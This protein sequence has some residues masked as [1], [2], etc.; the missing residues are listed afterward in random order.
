MRKTATAIL[1]TALVFGIAACEDD[2]VD[3]GTD[4]EFAAT[5]GP[6]GSVETTA[7]GSAT[8]ERADGVVAYA[9]N[10]QNITGV[11]AAH[12]HGPAGAGQNAGVI[13]GLF[14]GPEG[15]TGDV[16][17][18]LVTGTFTA[19]NLSANAGVSM[20]SLLVLMRNGQAYVN[21][22]TAVNPGGEIRG[23]ITS[24]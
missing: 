7:T 16:T 15:G 12:I 3:I 5:L 22:H 2:L 21:V 9:I 8:F 13:V 6:E 10:V 18:S 11:T 19:S 20:D 4:E 1:A 24:Q 17:G 23:Q 14:T